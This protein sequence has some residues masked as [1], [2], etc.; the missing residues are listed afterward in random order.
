MK[1]ILKYTLGQH[2]GEKTIEVYPN[3]LLSVQSQFDTV[4]IWMLCET[5]KPKVKQTYLLFETGQSIEPAEEGFKY[6]F[7]GTVQILAGSYVVHVF[8]KDK[9]L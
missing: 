4:T 9:E 3:K 5:D 7:I 2:A 6:S 8:R 1:S